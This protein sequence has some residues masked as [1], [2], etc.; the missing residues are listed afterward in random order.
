M[1]FF[2][3]VDVTAISLAPTLVDKGAGNCEQNMDFG[4]R[5]PMDA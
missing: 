1:T 2:L 4:V 5:N 3:S